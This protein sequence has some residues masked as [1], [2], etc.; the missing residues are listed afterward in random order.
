MAPSPMPV[1][2]GDS[3]DGSPIRH[4]PGRDPRCRVAAFRPRRGFVGAHRGPGVRSAYVRRGACIVGAAL[5]AA[6]GGACCREQFRVLILVRQAII[7]SPDLILHDVPA[8][9]RT[10]QVRAE[11]VRAWIARGDLPAIRIGRQYRVRESVLTSW[12]RSHE[13]R[14]CS[15]VLSHGRGR[16]RVPSADGL[17][18]GDS[19]HIRTGR[20]GI[21]PGAARPGTSPASA[22]ASAPGAYRSA[23]PSI[24]SVSYVRMAQ[25]PAVQRSGVLFAG[26]FAGC[27]TAQAAQA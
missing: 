11:T 23:G 8:V 6:T 15:T 1:R 17:G 2:C 9:A 20:R 10:L 22:P 25:V 26:S 4:P 7:M 13:V 18:S 27:C 14:G 21:A 12:V 19:E 3:C 5:S 16:V 24:D